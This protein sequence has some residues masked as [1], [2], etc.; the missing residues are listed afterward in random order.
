MSHHR[1]VRFFAVLVIPT[2]CGVYVYE[3]E[4]HMIPVSMQVGQTFSIL[5][6][7]IPTNGT[8]DAPPTYSADNPA[9]V[10]ITPAADGLSAKVTALASGAVTISANGV[11]LGNPIAGDDVVV[12]A[13]T[14]P[15]VPATGLHVTVTTPA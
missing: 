3:R 14:T 11:S 13:I 8:L 1:E 10:T 7:P 4:R 6:V 9:L 2:D 15:Q 12:V 5:L